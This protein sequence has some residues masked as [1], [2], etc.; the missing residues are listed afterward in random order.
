MT[1]LFR[2]VD[3]VATDPVETWPLEAVVTALQR[4]G[5]HEWRRLAV[6]IRRDPWGQ[7][8]RY[9]E[10]AVELSHPFGVSQVMTDVIAAARAAA[11]RSE[12]DEVARTVHR[13][14][15]ASGLSRARFASAVGTSVPRL[16]TYLTGKV[17]PSST[18][19]VRMARV[20]ERAAAPQVRPRAPAP[21][22]ARRPEPPG[23][24]P[25]MGA[26]RSS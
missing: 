7:V 13:L 25:S 22:Q 16:S 15:Q 2:N 20:A 14:V 18:L 17:A 3:A 19:L 5:L 26:M 23:G 4:G 12:R 24:V 10:E 9:V 6:V 11:E 1:L 8:A 21:T